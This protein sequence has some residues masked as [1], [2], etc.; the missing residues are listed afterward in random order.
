MPGTFLVTFDTELIWGSYEDVSAEQFERHY[1]DVRGT[2]A[3]IV[4]LLETYRVTATWAVVGHL[5]LEQ[6]R[7]APDGRA[8]PEIVRPHSEDGRDRLE[9]DPCSR[10]EAEPLWYGDD[11]IEQLR[12]ARWPQEIGCHSFSHVLFGGADCTAEVVRSELAACAAIAVERGIDLKSFVFPRNEEGHHDLLAEFGFTAYRG[13]DPTWY[14][15]LPRYARRLAHYLDQFAAVAP[16]VVSPLEM[17]PGLWNIP[18][19]M[20]LLHRSGVRK[21]IPLSSPVRK[22]SLGMRRAAASGKAFHLWT[23]PFGLASDREAMLAVLDAILG[24]AASLRDRGVLRIVTMAQLASELSEQHRSPG[25]HRG[26]GE[27]TV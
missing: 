11:I 8:H 3:R 7:R 10:R 18:G 9:A 14:R 20:L 27:R 12:T 22:A 2:I 25:Q 17:R 1:P 19:S 15:S 4:E 6:C 24:E 16:P 21:L 23:H 5:F 26:S 13:A